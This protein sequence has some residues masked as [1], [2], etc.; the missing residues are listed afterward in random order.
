[1]APGSGC[2]KTQPGLTQSSGNL[3]VR[4]RL[5]EVMKTCFEVAF[6]LRLPPPRPLL[7]SGAAG[8]LPN[9]FATHSCYVM[10][11]FPSL[12]SLVGASVEH[13]FTSCFLISCSLLND[14]SPPMPCLPSRK[15]SLALFIPYMLVCPR[16]LSAPSFFL[17][18]IFLLKI[19]SQQEHNVRPTSIVY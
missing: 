10:G 4:V 18:H 6:F 16:V 14:L 13:M 1:M 9:T 12:S 15:T 8:L 19:L 5:C 7:S 2:W 11:P 17:E 3:G